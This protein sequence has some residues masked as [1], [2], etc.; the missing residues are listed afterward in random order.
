MADGFIPLLLL[1]PIDLIMIISDTHFYMPGKDLYNP[2][3]IKN[4]PSWNPSRIERFPN[5][6]LGILYYIL[7][8][9]IIVNIGIYQIF[10]LFSY[11]LLFA[12]K[13]S[14]LV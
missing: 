14:G 13:I 12:T 1:F 8:L 7:N 6:L 10:Y 9:F 3:I 5:S 4:C 11:S 2:M